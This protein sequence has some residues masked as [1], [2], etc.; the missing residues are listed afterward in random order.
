MPDLWEQLRDARADDH[1]EEKA[2][3]EELRQLRRLEIEAELPHPSCCDLANK[4]IFPYRMIDMRTETIQNDGVPVWKNSFNTTWNSGDGGKE[5]LRMNF[6]PFCGVKLPDLRAK[7]NPPPHIV[8]EDGR[9]NHCGR[10]GERFGMGYCFCSHPEAAF[11][12]VP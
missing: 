5:F 8:K 2:A 1:H 12:C 3:T 9:S 10:C 6:C 7:K 11:E 4:H